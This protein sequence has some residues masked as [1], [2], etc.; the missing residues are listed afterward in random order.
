MSAQ[1][2]RQWRHYNV[3]HRLTPLLRVTGCVS[4][5]TADA[6]TRRVL[7]ASGAGGGVC[8]CDARWTTVLLYFIQFPV[9]MRS[10]VIS[11]AVCL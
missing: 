8:V 9:E 2:H 7:R 10:Y 5:T 1:Q 4:K 6:E 11:T 3:V